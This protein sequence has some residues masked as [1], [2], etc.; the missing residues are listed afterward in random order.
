M[1]K[2]SKTKRS[3]SMSIYM[4]S[5]KKFLDT[6]PD[7]YDFFLVLQK[8]NVSVKK[9]ICMLFMLGICLK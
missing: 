3:A 5:F 7:R 4:D 1:F 6:L 2:I 8:I 9:I